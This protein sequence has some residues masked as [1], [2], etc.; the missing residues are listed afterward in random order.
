MRHKLSV[1]NGPNEELSANFGLWECLWGLALVANQQGKTQSTMGSTFPMQGPLNC[2]REE[3]ESL[4]AFIS[5]C[6]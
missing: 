4:R 3:R 6:S 2:K 1:K 5:L